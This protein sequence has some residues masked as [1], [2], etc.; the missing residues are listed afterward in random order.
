[1]DHVL[2]LQYSLDALFGTGVSKY[3]PKNGLWN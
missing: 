2:K 3:L 1:M